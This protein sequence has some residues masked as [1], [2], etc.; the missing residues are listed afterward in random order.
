MEPV[1]DTRGF[2]AA[3]RFQGARQGKVFKTGSLGTGYYTD[4]YALGGA[5]TSNKSA[6]EVLLFDGLRKQL[7]ETWRSCCSLRE[8][9]LRV[10][11]KHGAGI[12]LEHS[13]FGFAV[14]AIAEKPGQP[15]QVGDVIVAIESRLLAGLSAPQMEASFLKRRVEGAKLQVATLS[16]VEQ[17]SKM[18][19]AVAEMWDAQ[20]QRNYYFHKKTG[21]SAWTREELSRPGTA[22][23]SK[24]G[25]PPKPAAPID[26]ASFLSHGFTQAS[27][28]A[29]K[30]KRKKVDPTKAK[31]ESQLAREEKKRWD[32]W[33]A[34]ERGG[35]T[36]QF[37]DKYKNCQS[38][39]KKEK[40]KKLLKGSVGPG[41]G[42]EYMARWTGS[43][44]SF[45]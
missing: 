24:D 35:Y 17:L 40:E 6:A 36:E 33:N 21:Q 1:E 15:V 2:E 32:D 18:D 43:K 25:A 5:G 12:S 3:D 23:G 28:V 34:G 29:P 41:Q 22:T 4:T 8:E 26:I 44:N 31:D 30:A 20:H 45:N 16:E 19:P 10:D 37:L 11:P 7:P 39:P 42:M 13:E 27:G 9:K 14:S 38:N